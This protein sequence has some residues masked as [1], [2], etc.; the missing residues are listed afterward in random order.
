M[1]CYFK[2]S[3]SCRLLCGSW[4]LYQKLLRQIKIHHGLVGVGEGG[5]LW[6]SGTASNQLGHK[7]N[8]SHLTKKTY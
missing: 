8:H 5:G 2:K 3:V 7:C 1:F 4:P 6:I